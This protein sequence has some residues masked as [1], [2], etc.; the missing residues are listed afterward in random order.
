MF[1]A[2]VEVTLKDKGEPSLTQASF[3]WRIISLGCL[4]LAPCKLSWFKWHCA[5]NSAIQRE[6]MFVGIVGI[7]VGAKLRRR[8]KTKYDKRDV[9]I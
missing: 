3:Q 7:T 1:V 8:E 2:K 4:L 6:S 5:K 9:F